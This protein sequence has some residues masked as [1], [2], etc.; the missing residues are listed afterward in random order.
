[1]WFKVTINKDGSVASCEQ[2]AASLENGKTI[3][4]VEADSAELALQWV[5][6]WQRSLH[7][8]RERSARY[9]QEAMAAGMCVTCKRVPAKEGKVSCEACLGDQRQ[10]ARDRRLDLREPRGQFSQEEKLRIYQERLA[11]GLKKQKNRG[12]NTYAYAQQ[13]T[14]RDTLCE[15]LTKFDACNAVVFRA[16]LEAEMNAA[17]EAR[18]RKRRLPW[19]DGQKASAAE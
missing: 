16:W 18:P 10:Y 5:N 12:A 15:V 1:M 11:R 8:A 7:L 14:R 6:R 17:T 2:V 19:R 9:K 3:R 13:V 4:Y